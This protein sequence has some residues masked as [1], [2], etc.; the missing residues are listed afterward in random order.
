MS[1]KPKEDPNKQMSTDNIIDMMLG[2]GK[3]GTLDTESLIKET[4][5]RVW[6][7][8][9]KGYEY[10]Y[11]VDESDKFLRD[12]VSQR[13]HMI[14][15]FVDLV[16]ST[17]MS[18]ILPA[19]KLGI[20]ISSFSQE[21]RYVIK[22][23]GGYVLK[24]VGDAVIG[25]FI[26]EDNPLV[27]ADSA[28]SCARTM[29]DIIERGINPIL[30]EYDYPELRVKIGMDFGENAI[31][32]YGSDK[33]RSHVDILGPAVSIA[34]KI[35]AIARPNQILIGEDV[36]EKLHPSLKDLFKKVEWHASQWN[37]HD[38]KT[39]KLYGVYAMHV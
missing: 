13:M 26:A 38:K 29:I 25:Y 28:V 20:I 11:S 39:G 3:S 36:Y 37:Y 10:D 22:Y 14:V 21:M 32:R 24:Y 31:V 23:H 35:T 6:S 34:A 15:L 27:V 4:Q 9:K 12:N 16:G 7:S 1:D 5:K 18:L 33:I 19:E 17:D 2:G 8:L 30:S